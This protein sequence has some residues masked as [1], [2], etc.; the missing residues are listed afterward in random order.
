[1]TVSKEVV[2]PYMKTKYTAT[3]GNDNFLLMPDTFT[4]GMVVKTNGSLQTQPI[5]DSG[6]KFDVCQ[7]LLSINEGNTNVL[8]KKYIGNDYKEYAGNIGFTTT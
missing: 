5:S 2:R 3:V 4:D 7:Q 8:D 6:D 1:M